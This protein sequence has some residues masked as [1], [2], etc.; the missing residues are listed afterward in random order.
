MSYDEEVSGQISRFHRFFKNNATYIVL[1]GFSGVL[2]TVWFSVWRLLPTRWLGLM[3]GYYY[4]EYIKNF[5]LSPA[6]RDADF[7]KIVVYPF[8]WFWL[9][10]RIF[11]AFHI[12]PV[13]RLYW[14]TWLVA[15]LLV[16]WGSYF[17]LKKFTSKI[18]ATSFGMIYIAIIFYQNDVHVWQKPQELFAY[19]IA[20]ALGARLLLNSSYFNKRQQICTGTLAGLLIGIYYPATLI[21][22][23][24]VIFTIAMEQRRKYFINNKYFLI[25]MIMVALPQLYEM[26][27]SILMYH[28]LGSYPGFFQEEYLLTS[29]ISIPILIIWAVPNTFIK[30]SAIST[31][32]RLRRIILFL[33][34]WFLVQSTLYQVGILLPRSD[35]ILQCA[36][37]LMTLQLVLI[38][39]EFELKTKLSLFTIS[40]ICTLIIVSFADIS[41]NQDVLNSI[42]IS[43]GRQSNTNLVSAAG[44]YE[45]NSCGKS[46]LANG[47]FQFLGTLTNCDTP[48]YLP[49]NQAY[50]TEGIN[51]SKRLL[52]IS[53]IN[54]LSSV[55]LKNTFQD[56]NVGFVTLEKNIGTK[57]V[58][59]QA[60]LFI[61]GQWGD[62]PSKVYNIDSGKLERELNKLGWKTLVN[63]D[64]EL[65]MK[66]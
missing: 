1:S 60:L 42:S 9:W 63:S 62:A 50:V 38:F 13:T 20:A 59:F 37:A 27:S 29:W 64:N 52:A 55:E 11:S 22:L 25:S 66:K 39:Q 58:S 15:A 49:F 33:L 43:L 19:P 46:V 4:Q 51:Y 57:I 40:I 21:I 41:S 48:M 5:A 47:E 12:I 30:F 44:L 10:G 17:L 36:L 54:D 18:A 2:I 23:A 34:T 7:S 32:G 8:Y 24:P 3:D 65:V 16:V 53:H 35:I 31:E 14:V 28:N 61:K 6:L 45:Q 26:S 56:A